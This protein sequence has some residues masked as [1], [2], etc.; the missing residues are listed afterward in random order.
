VA[1]VVGIIVTVVDIA[2]VIVVE[3]NFALQVL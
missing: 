2:I 3:A 1:L